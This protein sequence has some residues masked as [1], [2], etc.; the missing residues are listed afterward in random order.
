VETGSP[1]D[2]RTDP[3]RLEPGAGPDARLGADQLAAQLFEEVD[4]P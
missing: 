3:V 4:Q 1:G 2:H